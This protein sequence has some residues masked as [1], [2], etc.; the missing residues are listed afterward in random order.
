MSNWIPVISSIVGGLLVW[1]GQVFERH[2]R[3]RTEITNNLQEIYADCR[4]LEAL[5]RN[6]YRELAMA[7]VHVEYWWYCFNSDRREQRDY[8][9]HLRSQSYAR[10]IERRIGDVK[11]DYIAHVCKFQ[12]IKPIEMDIEKELNII[13]DLSN[14]KAKSYESALFYDKVRNE[15]VDQ[16]ETELREKYYNNLANFRKINDL[17]K[18]SIN[19]AQ[20]IFLNVKLNKHFR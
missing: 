1:L 15:L 20:K 7:K 8:E 6:N 19:T 18:D 9:E 12:I 14:P 10:E 5:M 17:L 13:S 11:A 16:D 3:K 2:N 4:K